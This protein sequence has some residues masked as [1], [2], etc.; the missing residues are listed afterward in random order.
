LSKTLSKIIRR[1]EE[2]EEKKIEKKRVIA[3]ADIREATTKLGTKRK[4]RSS[5][6]GDPDFL[7]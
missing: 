2:E 4:T 3:K 5:Q 6:E 1:R 7:I